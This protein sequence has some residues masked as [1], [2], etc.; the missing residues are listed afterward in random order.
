MQK[1]LL[2]KKRRYWLIGL[3]MIVFLM[4]L[5]ATAVSLGAMNLGFNK[6][7]RI[8]LKSLYPADPLIFKANEIA[9]VWDIRLPRIIC[10]VLIGMG[11][12]AAGVIFQGLLHNPLAD[13]YTLG[14]S[15]GA[16]FGASLAIFWNITMGTQF[17]IMLM[18]FIFAFLTLLTV[19][20]IAKRGGGIL[21]NN[22]IIAGIIVSAILSSGVSFLK[23]MAGEEVGAIVFWLMGS[24][25]A[26]TWQEVWILSIIVLSSIAVAF[27]F[28]NDLN[29]LALGERNA[30]SLGVNIK[31]TNL[32]Y[33]IL[34][35]SLTA[36]CVATG[37]II[38]FIGLIVP[39]MLRFWLTA[40]HRV[41]LLLSALMG[42]I[43]LSLADNIARLLPM[44][45]IPVGVLTTL[46]GGP[47]FIYVFTRH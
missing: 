22:L 47:F 17:S 1:E 41:L 29:I 15:T 6:S 3:V 39:H 30:E 10:G 43:I 23:M 34:G 35:A 24:L 42:G 32:L 8:L 38:G 40:D 21:S 4:L 9:V 11:L 7:W 20:A 14:V 28:A 44:G 2:K 16:A 12:A 37:G 26:K 27:V 46:V 31:R 33:L 19:I 45:E 25:V 18:A 13:P 36:V 5:I